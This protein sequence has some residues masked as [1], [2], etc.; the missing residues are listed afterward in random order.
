MTVPDYTKTADLLE[1]R[2]KMIIT[3]NHRFKGRQNWIHKGSV[4]SGVLIKFRS[5]SLVIFM[6]RIPV[7]RISLDAFKIAYENATLKKVPF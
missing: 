2:W 6:N 5:S 7:R 4:M 1:Q 3:K